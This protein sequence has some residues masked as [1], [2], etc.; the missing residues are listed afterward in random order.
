MA[1]TRSETRND[2]LSLSRILD[3]KYF[4]LLPSVRDVGTTLDQLQWMALL[5]KV[6]PYLSNVR[7]VHLDVFQSIDDEHCSDRWLNNDY[8]RELSQLFTVPLTGQRT[9]PRALVKDCPW[10]GAMMGDH[11]ATRRGFRFTSHTPHRPGEVARTGCIDERHHSF[12]QHMQHRA[13]EPLLLELFQLHALKELEHT[14]PHVSAAYD[15]CDVMNG[16]V[17]AQSTLETLVFH[18]PNERPWRDNDY[19]AIDRMNASLYYETEEI[20]PW[21]CSKMGWG[22]E[23]ENRQVHQPEEDRASYDEVLPHI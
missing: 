4:I 23:T 22:T 1:P 11:T 14:I 16:L 5:K 3:V 10:T 21:P 19:V 7:S 2:T 12:L 17:A 8:G 13:F 9:P 15:F 6:L 20:P 18:C